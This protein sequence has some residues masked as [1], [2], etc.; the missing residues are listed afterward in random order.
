MVQRPGLEGAS[1]HLRANRHLH[2]TAFAPLQPTS[3]SAQAL[4]AKSVQAPHVPKIKS[5]LDDSN[6]DEYEDE[7]L[8]NYPDADFPKDMFMEF[9]EIWVG[10]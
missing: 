9:A 10:K 6:F 8:Q 2:V 1:L 5:Q 3:R 7:G 4:E